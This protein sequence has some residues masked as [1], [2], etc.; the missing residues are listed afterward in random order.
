MRESDNQ[1]QR[2]GLG[3][4]DPRSREARAGAFLREAVDVAELSDADIAHIR[5]RLASTASGR[6]RLLVPAFAAFGVIF[7]AGG[8]LAALGTFHRRPEPVYPAT[9]PSRASLV[10]PV[11][12]AKVEAEVKAE[13]APAVLAPAE[14]PPAQIP[15]IERARPS[16][17]SARQVVESRAVLSARPSAETQSPSGFGSADAIAA[18]V[19]V[20]ALAPSNA[21]VTQP[22][23]ATAVVAP[24][25]TVEP[26]PAP[27][28]RPVTAQ[29]SA[30]GA[31]ARSLSEVLERWRRQGR[32]EA[33]LTL[34]DEHDRRFPRGLL[35]VESRVARAEIL[36]A[37]GRT[38][39]ALG[40]LDG[41]SLSG[42]PRARELETL[43]GDLRAQAG[44]CGD[45]RVDLNAVLARGREDELGRRAARA[46]RFCP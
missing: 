28:A 35:H 46:L 7:V 36:L 10:R 2:L 32:A 29:P 4:V 18:R 21:T 38:L 42:L 19:P 6:R 22:A 12:E 14:A 34:L 9:S 45:A 27:S 31:E 13:A 25:P 15:S 3:K 43:R 1:P 30:A 41:L 20:A 16:A 39:P 17:H 5:L 8:V 11:H 40:V 24:T 37:L 26:V 23:P 33:A 44:R